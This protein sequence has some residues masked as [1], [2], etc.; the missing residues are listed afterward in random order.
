MKQILA[1]LEAIDEGSSTTEVIPGHL[2]LTFT[3]VPAGHLLTP[4]EPTA[5]I[6]SEVE[7]WAEVIKAANIH[8]N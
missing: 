2:K 4:G 1:D 6:K 7:K 3:H 5:R 8:P